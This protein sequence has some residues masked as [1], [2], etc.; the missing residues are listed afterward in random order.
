MKKTWK[1]RIWIRNVICDLEPIFK[2]SHDLVINMVAEPHKNTRRKNISWFVI[3]QRRPKLCGVKTKRPVNMIQESHYLTWAKARS[4]GLRRGSKKFFD[5]K[6]WKLFLINIGTV[7]SGQWDGQLTH[8]KIRAYSGFRA[9]QASVEL[10][11][12]GPDTKIGKDIRA[13]VLEVNI[14]PYQP[15]YSPF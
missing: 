14:G 2:N 11:F 4:N 6:N 8:L 10:S 7:P 3:H 5:Q 12:T 1:N 9:V 15:L 13:D